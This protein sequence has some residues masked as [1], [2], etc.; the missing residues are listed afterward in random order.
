[1]ATMP[2]PQLNPTGVTGSG[3]GNVMPGQ[4]S[5]PFSASSP[6]GPGNMNFGNSMN[7]MPQTSGT[8]GG[9]AKPMASAV[10][11]TPG[12]PGAGSVTS[13][14]ATTAS[15]NPY[16]L[17]QS[18]MNWMQK[19]LQETY[20]GGM[21]ALV[22][23]YLM[24]NGGYN[25]AL[26]QQTVDAT[27]NA[28]QQQ[29]TQGANDLTA[30]LS[31][32]GVTGGSSEMSL[33]LEQYE[34]GVAASQNQITAQDYYQMWS[35]SQSN[36]LNMM[37]FAAQGTGTTLANKPNW[38]DYLNEGLGIAGSVVGM[39]TGISEAGSLAKIAGGS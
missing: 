30:R 21:G 27:S 14:G 35:Q 36:E 11:P 23:Q 29:S 4:A 31:A 28:M 20:G 15:Q 39:G 17:A 25:S 12:T 9:A 5:T 38:M 2:I 34:Q 32:M 13:E 7:P 10:S 16:G 37:E 26:T 8:S 22:Y 18:Q 19:Y 33:P 1:M 6:G 3:S 24:S